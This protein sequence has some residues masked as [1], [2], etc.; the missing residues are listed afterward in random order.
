MYPESIG[1]SPRP[2]FFRDVTDLLSRQ[3]IPFLA[4]LDPLNTLLENIDLV[5]ATQVFGMDRA[6]RGTSLVPD[7]LLVKTKHSRER[8][9]ILP[10]SSWSPGRLNPG[11]SFV[12]V[13]WWTLS[14]GTRPKHWRSNRHGLGS[15]FPRP[16]AVC[17]PYRVTCRPQETTLRHTH[18][19]LCAESEKERERTFH[20]GTKKLHF[21]RGF[22]LYRFR[23]TTSHDSDAVVR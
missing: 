13:F 4:S 2:P 22:S 15:S 1:R 8:P 12:L 3:T 19:N 16:R 7:Q 5:P 17:T 10:A 9:A 6:R 18:G 11:T 23:F 21:R 14:A 20:V